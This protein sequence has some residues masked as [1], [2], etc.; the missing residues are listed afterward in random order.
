[1]VPCFV[2]LFFVILLLLNL[3][4]LVRS[5]SKVFFDYGVTNDGG[6]QSTRGFFSQTIQASSSGVD[7]PIIITGL[8]VV[9]NII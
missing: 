1:M 6:D 2:Y 8:S 9:T 5:I 7:D 4:P 3:I